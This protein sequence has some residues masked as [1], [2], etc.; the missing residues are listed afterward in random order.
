[1]LPTLYDRIDQA[2]DRVTDI[3]R[4]E[5]NGHLLS[6]AKELRQI[7]DEMPDNNISQAYD[8]IMKA[9]EMPD[10]KKWIIAV[11]DNLDYDYDLYHQQMIDS[12]EEPIGFEVW[13]LG[14]WLN[15]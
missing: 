7:R 1:M 2:I 3:A 6:V 14:R 11:K 9:I 10:F 8:V 5:G 15:D 13:A 4:Y 12:F